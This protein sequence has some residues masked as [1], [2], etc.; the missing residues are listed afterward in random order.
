MSGPS[1]TATWCAWGLPIT[2]KTHWATWCSST[3]Q[4]SA[5]TLPSA[6]SLVKSSQRNLYLKYI[7]PVAGTVS[8]VNE[9]LSSSPESVNAD[10]YGSGWLCEISVKSGDEYEALLDAPA[11]E[12]LTTQ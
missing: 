5:A 7:P 1:A 4:K 10:P 3:Y 9:L 8:A 11:Y 6:P 12:A 2:P